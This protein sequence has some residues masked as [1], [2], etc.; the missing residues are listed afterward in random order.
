M[1]LPLGAVFFNRIFIILCC[2]C[3]THTMNSNWLKAVPTRGYV[4]RFHEIS[5]S[6]ATQQL[7]NNVIQTFELETYNLVKAYLRTFSKI[8]P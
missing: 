8:F 7:I 1:Y 4:Y 3:G 2:R 5:F 6:Y